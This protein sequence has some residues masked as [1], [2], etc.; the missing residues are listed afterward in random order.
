MQFGRDTRVDPFDLLPA[1]QQTP[2]RLHRRDGHVLAV[3]NGIDLGAAGK[4][5]QKTIIVA[6]AQLFIVPRI[7]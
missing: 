4:L 6:R 1:L 7:T 3:D 5:E 2:Y